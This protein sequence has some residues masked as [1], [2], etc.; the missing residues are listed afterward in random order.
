MR[1]QTLPEYAAQ[2]VLTFRG[3]LALIPPSSWMEQSRES[4]LTETMIFG[5]WLEESS[6]TCTPK[7]PLASITILGTTATSSRILY[8]KTG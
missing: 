1:T 3:M 5:H 8:S 7:E 4:A 6:L 2:I